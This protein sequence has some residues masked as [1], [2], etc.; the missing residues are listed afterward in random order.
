MG[1]RWRLLQMFATDQMCGG[2][3][4]VSGLSRPRGQRG[5]PVPRGTR[6]VLS[7]QVTSTHVPS[8]QISSDPPSYQKPSIGETRLYHW[9]IGASQ[10]ITGNFKM[11]S[12]NDDHEDSNSEYLLFMV[13]KVCM[14]F[15]IYIILHLSRYIRL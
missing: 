13:Y 15:E 1:R 9:L 12:A 6:D 5:L 14:T 2:Q 7:L 3:P 4:R 8:V 11:T 10:G